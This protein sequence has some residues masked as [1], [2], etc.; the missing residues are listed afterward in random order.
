[1]TQ[2]ME[3]WLALHRGLAILLGCVVALALLGGAWWERGLA[4][5]AVT[6]VVLPPAAVASPVA[7][8]P[9]SPQPKRESSWHVARDAVDKTVL[10][11]LSDRRAHHHPGLPYHRVREVPSSGKRIALTIDDGPHYEFT[12]Q[13]LQTLKRYNVK[14]TFFLVGM[15]AEQAPDLVRAEAAAG[16]EIGNHTY[17]HV[18]L[19]KTSDRV[20]AIEIKACGEVIRRI[21]GTSPQF[22]RPPG[23]DLNRRVGELA[24]LLGYTVVMWSDCPGDH[25]EPGKQATRRSAIAHASPGGIL[26]LH[27]GYKQTVEVLPE[28]IEGLQKRG[29]QFVTL[30]QLLQRQ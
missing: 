15:M 24:D 5:K 30:S 3:R 16:H 14:A 27:D 4:A 22:F 26:I 28:I 21:T 19:V 12:P 7:A 8:K 9:Q 23:G 2:A 17:H 6:R 29:Y 10:K 20:T 18:N 1:M 25:L 11:L 13:L